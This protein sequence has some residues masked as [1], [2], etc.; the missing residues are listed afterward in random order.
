VLSYIIGKCTSAKGGQLEIQSGSLGFSA[1][2][3]SRALF[4][5]IASQ[6]DQKVFT[7]L[8]FSDSGLSMYAFIDEEEREMFGHLT[9]VNKVGPKAA[10]AILSTLTPQAVVQAISTNSAH[11]LTAAPGVGKKLAEAIVFSLKGALGAEGIFDSADF[12]DSEPFMA[13]EAS[14]AVLALESLGYERS[15]AVKKVKAA[16]QEGMKAEELIRASLQV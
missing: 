15:S 2:C 6:E 8:N 10:L 12:F 16:Y 4:A 9:S 3:S 1:Q 13:D 11:L 14:Q 7:H 5:L